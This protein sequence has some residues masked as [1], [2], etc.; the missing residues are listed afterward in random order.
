M[1][2]KYCPVLIFCNKFITSLNSSEIWDYLKIKGFG[3]IAGNIVENS[4]HNTTHVQIA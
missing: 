2:P 1:C 3:L 4:A